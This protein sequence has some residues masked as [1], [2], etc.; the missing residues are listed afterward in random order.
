MQVS[1]MQVQ[2]V[3]RAFEAQMSSRASFARQGKG[4]RADRV[5]LSQDAQMVAALRRKIKDLPEVREDR[6]KA[7]RQRISEGRYH[8]AADDIADLMVRRWIADGI[9]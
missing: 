5:D 9:R 2:A 8:V 3:A 6:V 1:R 4:P 7:L